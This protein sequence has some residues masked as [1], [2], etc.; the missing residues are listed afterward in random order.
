MWNL[1]RSLVVRCVTR[2]Y[3][4]PMGVRWQ[5]FWLASAWDTWPDRRTGWAALVVGRLLSPPTT[6]SPGPTVFTPEVIHREPHLVPRTSEASQKPIA[7]ELGAVHIGE[8]P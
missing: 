1:S 7:N 2:I 6:A 3:R 5:W 8:T 4:R